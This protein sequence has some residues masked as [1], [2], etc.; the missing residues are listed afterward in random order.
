VKN[1][2]LKLIQE[3][4]SIIGTDYHKTRDGCFEITD[5]YNGWSEEHYFYVNHPGYIREIECKDFKTYDECED[6]LVKELNRW[7]KEE[8]EFRFNPDGSLKPID[9]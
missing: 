1:S 7:I 6:Y 8:R 3:Y 2:T 9:Y 5:Y 4:L